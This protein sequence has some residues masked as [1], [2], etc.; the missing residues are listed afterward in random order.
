MQLGFLEFHNVPRSADRVRDAHA[1]GVIQQVLRA[2]PAETK[3]D[4][5][6]RVTSDPLSVFAKWL[7]ELASE[8]NTIQ[9]QEDIILPGKT[10]GL[11]LRTQYVKI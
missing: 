4:G 11:N 9:A 2:L 7:E 10:A 8:S 1:Y 3:V 5:L 6:P